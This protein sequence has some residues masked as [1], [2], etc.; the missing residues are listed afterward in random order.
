MASG[1]RTIRHRPGLAAA[2]CV[3]VL[4]SHVVLAQ[5]TRPDAVA[6][7]Q[8][9]SEI[10]RA[11]YRF[12]SPDEA[13]AFIKAWP[14]GVDR[15]IAADKP[16]ESD[17]RRHVAALTALEFGRTAFDG[18]DPLTTGGMN[19]SLIDAAHASLRRLPPSEFERRWLRA[20]TGLLVAAANYSHLSAAVVRFP[21]DPRLR[22]NEVLADGDAR[23]LSH[24][25]G[26]SQATLL[27]SLGSGDRD[28]TT[29][30]IKPRHAGR[31]EGVFLSLLAD[32]EVGPEAAAR[33]GWLRFHQKN[34]VESLALFNRAA[35]ETHDPFVRNLA[36][37]GLGLTHL[38]QGRADEATAA[39]RVAKAALPAARTVTTALA[40]QLF[41]AGH[42]EEAS[43]I[44]DE[45]AGVRNSLDPWI[46][47]DGTGRFV[48]GLLREMR[49][50]LGVPFQVMPVVPALAPAPLPAA[51]TAPTPIAAIDTVPKPPDSPGTRP[52]FTA[53]TSMVSVDAA[54]MNGRR[55][56][57]GLTAADFEVRDN[58]VLQSIDSV[59][60]EGLPLDVTVVL[61][62]R[63]S[64]YWMSRGGQVT[65]VRD[66]TSQG[67]ADTAQFSAVLRPDDRLRIVTAT[68]EVAEPHPLQGPGGLAVQR[69]PREAMT[70]SALYD[71]IFTALARRT[72]P[73]RRHL[74]LVFTDG[75]DGS[76]IVTAR[77]LLQAAAKSDA[78][79]Q[80]FRR[81]TADEFFGRSGFQGQD[82]ISRSLLWPHDP[83]LLPALAEATSGTL[84]RVNSTG[85]SV[86][87]DVKRTLDTFRQRYILRYRP[88]GVEPGGWHTVGVRVTRPGTFT[89]RARRG[90]DGG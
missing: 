3:A 4:A 15:W 65:E 44:L 26:T 89:V 13:L 10:G 11:D 64:A 50:Q 19:E 85:Q 86:V 82:W 24:T 63:D 55:P 9:F 31:A 41:L 34:L 84:E 5:R 21:D 39:F 33:L 43:Q 83:E 74:V 67:V 20:T 90:Y 87:A 45:Q 53:I 80:V 61:D 46:H 42:R 32:P 77:Q 75:P 60:L 54:V 81:D 8:T 25:P 76:S 56:V 57:E 1:G 58:G 49:T 79:V 23:T 62:L 78:L 36:A 40:L 22:L 37:L 69:V 12:K 16:A 66:A 17:R 52:L 18:L 29:R 71:A 2:L 35:S 6:I 14:A 51:P 68:R 38:A 73:E 7:I 59:S 47:V 70:A 88:T 30:A 72:S 27:F 28:S 48:E